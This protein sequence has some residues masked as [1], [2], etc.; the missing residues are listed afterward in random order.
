MNALQGI[1][2]RRRVKSVPRRGPPSRESGTSSTAER[3]NTPVRCL[4]SSSCRES[5]PRYY[6]KW[7]EFERWCFPVNAYGFGNCATKSVQKWHRHGCLAVTVTW[8]LLW[9]LF[10]TLIRSNYNRLHLHCSLLHTRNAFRHIK[11]RST[12]QISET[13]RSPNLPRFRS[14]LVCE[15]PSKIFGM[16]AGLSC[17]RL[18]LSPQDFGSHVVIAHDHSQ[19][20]SR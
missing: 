17:I 12:R 14:N 11:V 20:Q 1:S 7:K 3:T 5:H 15:W 16:I 6:N 9:I 4:R 10:Q 8:Y 13:A 2:T 19:S 18:K